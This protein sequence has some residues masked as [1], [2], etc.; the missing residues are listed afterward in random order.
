MGQGLEGTAI[1]DSYRSFP[2]LTFPLKPLSPSNA[3]P[4]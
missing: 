2:R 4:L 3:L 1:P